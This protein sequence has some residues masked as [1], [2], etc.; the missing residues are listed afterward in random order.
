MPQTRPSLRALQLGLSG[1]AGLLDAT[2]FLIANGYF[3][4]FMSGNT[5]QL[6]VRISL[7]VTGISQTA[8]SP[9]G[10]QCWRTMRP[11]PCSPR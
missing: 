10:L 1:L 7:I 9:A 11:N 5:T 3:V 2:G 4:S 8:Q 6:G